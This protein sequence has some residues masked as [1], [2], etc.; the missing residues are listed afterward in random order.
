MKDDK[1]EPLDGY[2]NVVMVKPI[3]Q[4]DLLILDGINKLAVQ[5][6][7]CDCECLDVSASELF[8]S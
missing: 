7:E 1:D 8:L 3:E 4:T 2:D 5:E 6:P